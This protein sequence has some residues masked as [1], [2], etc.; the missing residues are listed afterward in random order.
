MWWDCVCACGN[1]CSSGIQEIQ[2][3]K[4]YRNTQCVW[5]GGWRDRSRVTKLPAG[6]NPQCQAFTAVTLTASFWTMIQPRSLKSIEWRAWKE[7]NCLACSLKSEAAEI[8]HLWSLKSQH[9]VQLAVHLT[10]SKKNYFQNTKLALL[11]L[12]K[13]TNLLK[14][15][16]SWFS[17][18]C[19]FPCCCSLGLLPF[20]MS[21]PCSKK[22]FFFFFLS[23]H[24]KYDK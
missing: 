2:G 5:R 16:S 4:K 22:I 6:L 24:K 23:E 12:K 7:S 13:A 11:Y 3:F 1:K 15:I 8:S 14:S 20:G 9:L 18:F 19:C 17:L 10:F 21:F